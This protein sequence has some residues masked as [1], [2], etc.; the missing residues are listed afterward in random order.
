MPN[1]TIKANGKTVKF[2][3]KNNSEAHS[4]AF[5]TSNRYYDLKRLGFNWWLLVYVLL[6]TV[7]F[8]FGW[9]LGG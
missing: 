6:F 1:Y 4:I 9:N 2:R 7:F 8:M 5:G 3:A